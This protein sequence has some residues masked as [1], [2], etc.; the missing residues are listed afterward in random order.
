MLDKRSFHFLL[1][2]IVC[3][4]TFF[5]HNTVIYPDIMES[6][7]LITAREIVQYDNWLVPT[8]NGELRLEKPPLPTWV[9]ALLESVSPDNV[10]L[11]RTAAGLAATLL[12]FFLYLLAEKLTRN[13]IYALFSALILCT[14]FNIILMGRTASWD[15]YCHSFMVGAIYFFVCGFQKQERCWKE[16]IGAGI[17]MGLSFLGKGP[18]SFYA[19]LLPFLLAY[20]ILYRPSFRKMYLPLVVSVLICLLIS[21]WWPLYLYLYH[22]D[23]ALYV[24]AKEST[25]WLERNVRPWYYYWKFFLESG[26]WSLFLVSALAWPYW[27]KRLK[28]RKEYLLVVMWTFFVLILLSLLPEKKT[29]YLLPILIPAALVVGHV[30]LY[31]YEK[32]CSG[33]LTGGE[34]LI[35]KINTILVAVVSIA[36]PVAVYILF[37]AK[38]YMGVGLFLSVI[39]LF[40]LVIGVLWYAAIKT[41]PFFFL[42]GVV[43]L[44]VVVEVMLMPSVASLF[45]NPD[46]K[47][48]HAVRNIESVNKLPF[49]YVDGEELRIELVYEAGRRILPWNIENDS[50]PFIQLPVVLVSEKSV[51]ETLP[52]ALLDKLDWKLIGVYDDNRRQKNTKFYSDLFIRYVTVLDVKKEEEEK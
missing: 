11:Q 42:S 5:I 15:I 38:G 52:P 17:F 48:I 30:F 6:R 49:Y 44:F 51:E 9:A 24:A 50:V 46:M 22:R 47:S 36:L 2:G 18:V 13:R 29:R 3:F 12:I 32:V 28:F 14:S 23:M 26:I 27:K 39:I 34:R 1:L 16:Y 7:N 19:L 35:F 21:L 25:A 40:L 43:M 10:G 41:R 45:N 37:Y 4:F 31:W 20:F 8:M 33:R